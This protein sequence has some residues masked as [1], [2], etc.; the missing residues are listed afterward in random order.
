M[1]NFAINCLC[2]HV[3]QLIFRL[4]KRKSN[5][6]AFKIFL[7]KC[8]S[9]STCLVRSCCTGLWEIAMAALLSQNKFIS[10]LGG[11]PISV[12]NLL[13]QSSSQRPLYNSNQ[14]SHDG[15]RLPRVQNLF[16][17]IY[18][19]L[20]RTQT[21]QNDYPIPKRQKLTSNGDFS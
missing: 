17:S 6:F 21:Y 16:F 3:C 11:K 2:K 18:N 8:R 5:Y 20:F 1:E 10:T 12:S 14:L 9:T 19:H 4:N 15:N 13:S 7:T